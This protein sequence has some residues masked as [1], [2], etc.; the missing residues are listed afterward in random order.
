VSVFVLVHCSIKRGN[1]PTLKEE[2]SSVQVRL[3]Q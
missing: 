1:G 3:R 2:L